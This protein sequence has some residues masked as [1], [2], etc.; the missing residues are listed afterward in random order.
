M[1]LSGLVYA[2]YWWGEYP[3]SPSDD[4]LMPFQVAVEQPTVGTSAMLT[5]RTLL[6][7][8]H[9]RTGQTQPF[10]D[11]EPASGYFTVSFNSAQTI[12][13][14]FRFALDER[15]RPTRFSLGKPSRE[16]RS[17]SV[18]LP[19]SST[20]PKPG[21]GRKLAAWTETGRSNGVDDFS[22]VVVPVHR[23]AGE[24]MLSIAFDFPVKTVRYHQHWG[25]NKIFLEIEDSLYG[26]RQEYPDLDFVDTRKSATPV[27]S[28]VRYHESNGSITLSAPAPDVELASLRS[29]QWARDNGGIS[30][31]FLAVDNTVTFW[32]DRIADIAILIL[33]AAI[34]ILITPRPE[35]PGPRGSSA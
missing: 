3:R 6:V 18:F 11:D 13:Q 28:E 33:G 2:I 9:T 15:L 7:Q 21:G 12:R 8:Q 31:Q 1:L 30:V 34:G 17:E 22:V 20:A 26:F 4:D 23:P 5:S 19:V 16:G 25:E 24:Y 10:F 32:M 35:P 27:A 14:T 29:M